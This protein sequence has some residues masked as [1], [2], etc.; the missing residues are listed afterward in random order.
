M[1]TKLVVGLGNPGEKYADTRHNVGFRVLDQLAQQLGG[2]LKKSWLRRDVLCKLRQ[3]KDTYLLLKPGTFMNRSGLAVAPLARRYK[4]AP[5]SVLVVYDDIYLPVGAL[6]VRNSGRDGGHNGMRS[7]SEALGT[8]AFPRLRVGVGPRPE[9][10][11]LIEFVLGE[12]DPGEL[13]RVDGSIRNAA[14]AAVMWLHEPIEKVM[15][16][17]N[18]SGR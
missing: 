15:N 12:F 17:F 13:G 11:D 9:D 6:R 7:L 10:G 1:S 4:V 14:D 8:N 5:E 16:T 3:N 18:G 2:R